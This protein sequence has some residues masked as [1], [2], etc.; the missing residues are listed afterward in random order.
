[1]Y[2]TDHNEILH[3]SRQ[4][5]RHDVREMSLWSVKYILN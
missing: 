4:Y 1:M 5:H 2:P 3:T